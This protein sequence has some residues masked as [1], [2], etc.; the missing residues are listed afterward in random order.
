MSLCNGNI[1]IRRTRTGFKLEGTVRGIFQPGAVQKL[2]SAEKVIL[3]CVRGVYNV[4][5][6]IIIHGAPAQRIGLGCQ[7]KERNQLIQICIKQFLN[8]RNKFPAVYFQHPA[9]ER[10]VAVKG[11]VIG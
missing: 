10:C 5:R 6:Q 3:E 1:Q 2:N 11:F 8:L 7:T 4:S 9:V